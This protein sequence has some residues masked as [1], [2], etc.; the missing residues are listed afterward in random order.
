MQIRNKI[1]VRTTIILAG[2]VLEGWAIYVVGASPEH[3]RPAMIVKNE[4]AARALYDVMIETIRDVESLSYNSVCSGPDGRVSAYS[5]WLKK[6]N[7]F[8]VETTNVPSLKCSTLVGDGDFLWIYWQGIRPFLSIDDN[9]THTKTQSDVYIK[10]AAPAGNNSIG[11][12]IDLLGIAWYGTILEPGTFHG[13][14]D[15]L[16]PYIDGIRSRGRDDVGDQECEVIEVSYMDAQLTR[17]FWI[18]RQDNLPRQVKQINRL[19]GNI[20]RV[21]EWSEVK[22]NPLIPQQKFA[23]SAPEGWRQWNAPGPDDVLLES[24]Q[25][26]PDFELLSADGGRI[27]LSDYRGKI[28]WLFVWRT[29]SPSCREAMPN[30]QKLH[31]KYEGGGLVILGFNCAD[32]KRIALRFMHES[33]V[34]FPTVLDSSDAAEDLMLRGYRNKTRSVPLNYIIDSQ[35][36]VVDAWCGYEEGSNRTQAALKKAGLRLEVE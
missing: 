23:W 2:V 16:E 32:D 25:T 3:W 8:R 21:E 22:L 36:K 31:D 5:I 10:K 24:G 35:G 12:E 17:Y 14:I 13:H 1:N 29:G 11:H 7:Y 27:K 34:T 6:P 33:S 4:P 30:L 9:E 26:A 18:S 15:I 20:V 19:S 28:V